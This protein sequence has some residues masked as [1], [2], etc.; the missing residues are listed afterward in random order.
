MGEKLRVVLDTNVWISITLDKKL[1]GEFPPLIQSGRIEV[2]LSKSLVRELGRVL[3]YQRINAILENAG[4]QPIVALSRIVR[5]TTMVR[6]WRTVREIEEDE[7][8]NRVLEC[9]LY[10]RADFIVS[11]DGH[12]LRLGE[13]KGIRILSP[14]RFL[15][16]VRKTG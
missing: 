10:A 13:F 12:L 6:T 16:L 1:A 2:F 9:A 14:R 11:G 7:P 4:V 5:S 8:D 3:S 15:D